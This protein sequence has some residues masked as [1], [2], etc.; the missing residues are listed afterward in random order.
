MTEKTRAAPKSRKRRTRK[1]R[2]EVV[3]YVVEIE[4]W[5]WSF[6]FGVSNMPELDGPFDD[7]RHLNMLG[8]MIRPA[9]YAGQQIRVSF[10]P[11]ENLNPD[12]REKL[13]PKAIGGITTRKGDLSAVL[14]MPA[15]VLP[16]L[17]TMAMADR[18][19]YLT[20]DGEKPRYGQGELKSFRLDM[21]YDEDGLPDE[22]PGRKS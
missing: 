9:K 7:Y 22:E 10:L 15:D 20:M 2:G 4:S 16:A 1:P 8:R 19:H 12:R 21:T 11:N 5:D 14:S 6:W 13:K 17:L 18:L 3:F